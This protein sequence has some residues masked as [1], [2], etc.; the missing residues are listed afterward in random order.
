MSVDHGT[1][2]VKSR[3]K[4]ADAFLGGRLQ[5]C[6]PRSGFR[7]GTDSVL[8]G[9]SV[10]G[11]T[12]ELLDLGCGAGV[13]GLTALVH[14]PALKADLAE[15][16]SEMVNFARQNLARNGLE[17]R[18]QVLDV[19]VTAPGAVR[20]AAGIRRD[21]YASVIANP[22]YFDAAGGTL[23]KSGSR[24][25]ARHMGADALDAWVKTA[26]ASAAPAGEVVFIY[27]AA[28]L[29]P[30]LAAFAQRF[31]GLTLLPLQP[32]AGAEVSRVLLRGIKGSRAP[33][34]ILSPKPLHG[35]AGNAHLPEIDAVLRGT[36]GWEW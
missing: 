26:A 13:A 7:A 1:E 30:L 15:S 5:I 12:G 28:G 11:G 6:Q 27:P 2:N 25:A 24:A 31:G 14:H 33:L 21:H 32:R 36:A 19:D 9:A 16:D 3:P 4:D 22:P 35:E 17:A 10:R 29:A 34:K 23:A 18:A 20:E 8:L